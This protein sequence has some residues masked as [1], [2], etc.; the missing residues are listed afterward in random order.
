MKANEIKIGQLLSTEYGLA[1]VI[2]FFAPAYI[3]CIIV[4]KKEKDYKEPKLGEWIYLRGLDLEKS[5]V[6]SETR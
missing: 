4:S 2:K 3:G 6:I 5:E 1:T